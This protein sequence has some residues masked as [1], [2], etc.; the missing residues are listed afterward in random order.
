MPS[1]F[2]VDAFADKPFAGNPAG[3]VPLSGAPDDRWM[4]QV[5]GEMNQAETA[6]FWP[7]GDTYRLRWFTLTVEVDLCG[8]ATLASAHVLWNEL[9]DSSLTVR[10]QTRSGELV[11][12]RDGEYIKMDFPGEHPT[13]MPLSDQLRSAIPAN[14]VWQGRN[15][16]DHFVELQSLELLLET[17]WSKYLP[18]IEA[19][20][21]R[22]LIVTAAGGAGADFTSRCFF[23]QSGVPEDS[24]TGSAHCALA[25]YWAARLGKTE[26]TGYQ[27]SQRGGF[28]NCTIAGERVLLKGSAVTTVR[29]ELAV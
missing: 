18:A 1:L 21:M 4:Q 22:G 29:G 25:P 15:R 16:M 7:E 27:A 13:E 24:V 20:A 8:H 17:N 26:L 23:P 28:V 11:C 2:L 12:H 19:L 3:V 6:F 5:A 14:P 10:F 9:S